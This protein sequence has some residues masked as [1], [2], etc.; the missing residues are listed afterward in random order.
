[1]PRKIKQNEEIQRKYVSKKITI[2]EVKWTIKK[3]RT[4]SPGPDNIHNRCLETNT[5]LLLQFLTSLFKAVIDCRHISDIWN[6]AR[7]ILLL[8]PK[9]ENPLPSSYRSINLLGCV[10]RLLERIAQ[11]RLPFELNQRNILS[12]HQAGFR[13]RKRSIYNVV[14][15]ERFA[16]K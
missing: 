6:K 15:L 9:K 10:G 11:Q 4:S 16:S 5:D 14:R 12:T 13:P 8:K 7:I 1:M 3:L 2:K